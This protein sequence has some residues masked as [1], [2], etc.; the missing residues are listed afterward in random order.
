MSDRRLT[1]LSR[2]GMIPI[3]KEGNDLYEPCIFGKQH[4]VKFV[5]STKHS[6]GVLDLVHSDIWGPA[7]VSTRGWAKYFVIFIDDY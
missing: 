4:R 7:P 1:K 2:R 5:N 3:L 6:E